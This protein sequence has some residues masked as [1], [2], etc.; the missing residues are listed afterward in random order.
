MCWQ[1]RRR[2]ELHRIVCI[3]GAPERWLR[4]ALDLTQPPIT[5]A[6]QALAVVEKTPVVPFFGPTTGFVISYTPDH[7]VRFNRK[8]AAVEVLKEHMHPGKWS[9]LSGRPSCHLEGYGGLRPMPD[10]GTR[11]YFGGPHGGI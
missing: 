7:A 1:S 8:G 9:F 10:E 11:A 2:I 6:A 5:F 4:I 3:T